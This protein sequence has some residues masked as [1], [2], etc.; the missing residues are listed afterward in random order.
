[1]LEIYLKHFNRR[2]KTSAGAKNKQ[3][4][5]TWKLK[6]KSTYKPAKTRFRLRP[7][8]R[9]VRLAKCAALYQKKLPNRTIQKSE[10]WFAWVVFGNQSA[11]QL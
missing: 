10:T 3:T 5:D 4:T 6:K 2:K 1:M 11:L 8:K 9:S 7:S